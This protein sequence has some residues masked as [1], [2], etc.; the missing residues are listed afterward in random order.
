LEGS[1]TSSTAERSTARRLKAKP[2]GLGLFFTSGNDMTYYPDTPF[3]ILL[4]DR[5]TEQSSVVPDGD[6]VG[7]WPSD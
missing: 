6:K 5:N 1:G 2:N 4:V 7:L 3:Q